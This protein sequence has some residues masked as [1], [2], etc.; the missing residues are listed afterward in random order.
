MSDPV[1][2]I[3]A[4]AVLLAALPSL[5][6]PVVPVRDAEPTVVGVPETVHVITPA[7]AM[8]VG[9]VGVQDVVSPAG[10]PATEQAAPVAAIAGVVA[11]EQVNV[12]L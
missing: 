3:A 6:A 4:V 7:G 12:P 2:A 1:T 9:G 5:V 10:N 8:V 11:F